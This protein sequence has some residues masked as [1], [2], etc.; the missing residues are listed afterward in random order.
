MEMFKPLASKPVDRSHEDKV[1][2][3]WCRASEV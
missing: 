3:V 2:R 1:S